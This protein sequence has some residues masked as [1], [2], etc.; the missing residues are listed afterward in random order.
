MICFTTT[1]TGFRATMKD[2]N[3]K[4]RKGHGATAAKAEA[5]LHRNVIHNAPSEPVELYSDADREEFLST[6]FDVA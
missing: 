1:S 2:A 5:N 6:F 4:V 3:G